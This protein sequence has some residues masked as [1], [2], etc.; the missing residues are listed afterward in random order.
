[1]SSKHI[2]NSNY[3]SSY[4]NNYNSQ[5]FARIVQPN[6]TSVFNNGCLDNIPSDSM[7]R[8]YSSNDS[9]SNYRDYNYNDSDSCSRYGDKI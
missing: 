2:G 7:Y 1:M 6:V 3:G 5:G 8:R 9:E 4:G